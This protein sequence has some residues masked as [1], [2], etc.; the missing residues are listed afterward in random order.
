[1]LAVSSS[2]GVLLEMAIAFAT[3]NTRLMQVALRD[4]KHQ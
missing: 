1:M 2:F 3:K 4:L